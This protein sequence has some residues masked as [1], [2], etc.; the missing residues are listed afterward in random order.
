MKLLS[1][2]AIIIISVVTVFLICFIGAT[3]FFKEP[4][5]IKE[6]Q[7]SKE[8]FSVKVNNEGVFLTISIDYPSNIKLSN[9]PDEVYL[10]N[11]KTDEQIPT[12]PPHTDSKE[13]YFT[14]SLGEG[15][16]L[17][18]YELVIQRVYIDVNESGSMSFKIPPFGEKEESVLATRLKYGV[19]TINEITSDSYGDQLAVN[20]KYSFNNKIE[21]VEKISGFIGKDGKENYTSINFNILS[22]QFESDQLQ[23]TDYTFYFDTVSYKVNTNFHYQLKKGE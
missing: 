20:L 9:L 22:L 1:K 17:E 19:M 10:L 7:I 11:L 15:Y 23:G 21:G 5:F 3:I 14:F 6:Q 4:N 8:S 12:F 13:K 18:D 2:K 16:A